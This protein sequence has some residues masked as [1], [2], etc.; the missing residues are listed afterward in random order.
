MVIVMV[1]RKK[2]CSI[3]M[4]MTYRFL[5]IAV[6]LLCFS[7]CESLN[8]DIPDSKFL[9]QFIGE[10]QEQM[11]ALDIS[12]SPDYKTFTLTADVLQDIGPYE[13]GDSSQ[14]RT[15][16]VETLDGIRM[17]RFST[18]QLV[19]IENIEAERVREYD[20]RLLL[21]V[22]LTLPQSDIDH[23]RAS[24]NEMRH[25]FKYD[26]MYVAFMDSTFVSPTMKVTDYVLDNYFKKSR[27]KYVCLYRSILQKRNEMLQ[28]IPVVTGGGTV[29]GEG[30]GY[31]QDANKLVMLVFSDGRM[32]YKDSDEP[33]DPNHYDYQE[34]LIAVDTA[35]SD[36]IFSAYYVS[37]YHDQNSF[38][39]Y[40]ENMLQLFC[41][42]NHGAFVRDFQWAN[43]KHDMYNN[44][45]LSF[46][47]NEF[48]F[49]NPD[50]KVYRGDNKKL[51]LK[52][53]DVQTDSLIAS[54]SKI[55]VLG[56]TFK[57]IIV[58]GHNIWYVI[59]QGMFLGFFLILGIYI[60]LQLI[61]PFIMHRRFL[62]KYVVSYT[63]QNM[64]FDNNV[65]EESCY[66]CKAPFETGEKIVVKC[67]HTMHKSCWDEN[68]YHCPEYSDRCK[69][70]SHYYNSGNVFDRR[71]APF[72]LG[73]LLMAVGM[74]TLAWIC[75]TLCIYYIK[76]SFAL[77]FF[78][79]SVTQP[80][81][82]GLTISFFLT[83]GFSLLV[84]RP[85]YD[86]RVIGRILLR[87]CIAAVASY[88][89]FFLINIVIYLFDIHSFTFLLNWIPWTV[90][91]FI[92]A[93]CSTW[94]V[95]VSHK[96]LLLLFSVLLGF[97][98]MYVWDF[99][100]RGLELDF[101]VLLLLSFIINGVAL[102]AC[103]A[104][105]SPRSERYFLKVEGAVKGMDVALYKWFRNNPKRVVTIGKSVD[106][107]LQMSWDI[108]SNIAPVQAEI[109]LKRRIP[110]LIPL[111][112]G[113]YLYGKPAKV[114]KSIRL[115]H[116]KTFSI[117]KTTFTYIEKD[118]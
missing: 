92:V 87:A 103:V 28:R 40:E 35:A 36:S 79:S 85:S 15:E 45:N 108:Q 8:Q 13:L 55:V 9:S 75:F 17:A 66:L 20:I 5:W 94:D 109:R 95:S 2:Y 57:P 24:V 97:L 21:L 116:G 58:N 31:W 91:G 71:N 65:V 6:A 102:A 96:K 77:G 19:K 112:S 3:S 29:D 86:F 101:R 11:K 74:S 61:V 88:L 56:E 46:P 34:Q 90:S 44:F 50:F 82:L 48:Y 76:G 104:T 7:A 23:I 114:N 69:H 118:R 47:D 39:D 107:S 89:S 1:N 52:F 68:D 73:W 81:V 99:L 51:T 113:V 22:D 93:Y 60:V 98:S 78:H 26:N 37:L 111:E 27:N 32:Y 42:N 53:Y 67:S 84:L 83:L 43:F 80:P 106:C 33:I 59:L 72:Y 14:V 49:V 41:N 12:F 70:G 10:D 105:V 110:Y 16:V 100:F 64:S 117:G 63:G 54:L 4:K 38:D 115:H 62:R 25:T 18:P 30:N